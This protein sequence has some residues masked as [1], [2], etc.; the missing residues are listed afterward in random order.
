MGNVKKLSEEVFSK[1]AAGEVIEKPSNVLK[2]LIE[3]SIDA[4]STVINVRIL[5]NGLKLIEVRDNGIGI[6]KDDL[7]LVIE[8]YTTSKINNEKDLLKIQTYGFRG[9]ALYAISKISNLQIISKTRNQDKAY[10]LTSSEG[11]IL[12]IEP[13]NFNHQ[14]GTI[15]KV[16]DLFFNT[17]VRKN[18]LSSEKLELYNLTNT[19]KHFSS[20]NN[21]ILFSLHIEDKLKY[22][23]IP[24]TPESRVREIFKLKEVQQEKIELENYRITLILSKEYKYNEKL[25]T[26]KNNFFV[27]VNRRIVF[28]NEIDRIIINT[29]REVLGERGKIEGIISIEA[30]PD[31]VDSNIHPRKLEVRFIKPLLLKNLLQ[32]AIKNFINNH[33]ISK[34]IIDSPQENKEQKENTN[35]YKSINQLVKKLEEKVEKLPN[36]TETQISTK[37]QFQTPNKP[38][39]FEKENEKETLKEVKILHYWDNCYFLALFENNFFVVD[40]HNASEKIIYSHLVKKVIDNENVVTQKLLIPINIEIENNNE[41]INHTLEF[42]EK[43]HFK[44]NIKETK[45]KKIM[46]IISYPIIIN[47]NSVRETIKFIFDNFEEG[48]T[49]NEEVLRNFLAKIS[50]KSAIK[51]GQKLSNEELQKLFNDLLSIDNLNP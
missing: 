49:D 24:T 29:F 40:Q 22:N 33:I 28:I 21:N 16:I 11:K 6:E 15:I 32:K 35:W 31:E 1:I 45:D 42:I 7:P 47:I 25:T 14:S 44:F 39:I 23:F 3:N 10:L 34:I 41:N 17:P 30:P 18:F 19:F 43:I 12:K 38:Q 51:K 26:Y 36:I 2:E 48:I 8:R 46:E 37:E 50:C 5:G 4:N 27:F 20:I 13:T 9:E